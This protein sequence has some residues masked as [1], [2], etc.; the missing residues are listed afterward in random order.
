MINFQSYANK[1]TI[2]VSVDE[3][4]IPDPHQ[5]CDDIAESLK[6]VKDA[7]ISQGLVEGV[8]LIPGTGLDAKLDEDM[9]TI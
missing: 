4:T 7:V 9:G 2:V 1:M 3:D 8:G 5:L 6:L